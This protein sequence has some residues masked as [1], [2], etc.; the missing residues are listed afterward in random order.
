MIIHRKPKK[1]L[2]IFLGLFILFLLTIPIGEKY[3]KNSYLNLYDKIMTYDTGFSS[4]HNL[5]GDG[6]LGKLDNYP[7][8]FKKLPK[9][10][11]NALF[12]EANKNNI[13]RIDIEI[14]FKNFLTLLED[15]KK[16]INNGVGLNFRSKCKN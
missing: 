9:V 2:F 4:I 7:K 3:Y 15:R 10:F 14:K 5:F 1:T 11:S 8:V 16:S 12:A 13:E 6:S